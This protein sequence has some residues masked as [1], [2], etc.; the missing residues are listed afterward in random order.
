MQKRF[1][2]KCLDLESK[3]EEEKEKYMYKEYCLKNYQ[4]KFFK[5]GYQDPHQVTL[6]GEKKKF[7]KR[8]KVRLSYLSIYHLWRKISLMTTRNRDLKTS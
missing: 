6:R 4:L 3:V 5:S 7:K 1:S 8:Y 2:D